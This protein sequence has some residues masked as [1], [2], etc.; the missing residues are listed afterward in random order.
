[1]VVRFI[2]RWAFTG[3]G[4]ALAAWIVPGISVGTND[5]WV[6]VAVMAL[7]LTLVNAVLRPIL[8]FLSC[9]CVV[10]TL[11]LFLFVINA[12]TL[13]L[14]SWIAQHWFSVDFV[15]EGFGAAVLGSLVVTLVSLVL[16]RLVPE[17]D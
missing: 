1:M 12:F 13:W 14:S 15:V 7:I 4:L 8:T 6:A 3:A 10:L 9:G 5:A 16:G 11:G 2:L 17:P